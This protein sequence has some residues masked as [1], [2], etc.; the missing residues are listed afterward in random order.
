M[1]ARPSE[2][3]SVSVAPERVLWAA[4]ATPAML[5]AISEARRAA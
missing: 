3:S 5:E 1:T 2:A 4:S